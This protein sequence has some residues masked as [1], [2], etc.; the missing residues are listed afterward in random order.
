[1]TMNDNIQLK[2]NKSD[3]NQGAMTGAKTKLEQYRKRPVAKLRESRE[4]T[5]ESK[6]EKKIGTI[7]K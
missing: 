3:C 1:M 4:G 5:Q 2:V 6:N 7:Q